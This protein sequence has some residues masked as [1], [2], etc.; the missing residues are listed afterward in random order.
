MFH[1]GPGNGEAVL[2]GDRNVAMILFA[3]SLEIASP[4]PDRPDAFYY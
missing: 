4:S 3:G 1:E 2:P